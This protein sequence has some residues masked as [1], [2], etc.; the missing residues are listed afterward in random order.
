MAFPTIEYTCAKLCATSL[1][2]HSFVILVD[3]L[4]ERERVPSSAL[5]LSEWA[6]VTRGQKARWSCYSCDLTGP[7]N[8]L[9]FEEEVVNKKGG[10]LRPA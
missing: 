7:L 6:F 1:S 8:G 4:R 2:S 3:F 5:H 9:V 10:V